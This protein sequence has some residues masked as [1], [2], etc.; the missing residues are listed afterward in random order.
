MKDFEQKEYKVFEMFSH[1]M[2]LV[3]ARKPGAFQRLHDW[4][5]QPGE[6]LVKGWQ[7]LPD[8]DRICLSFPIYL[9]VSKSK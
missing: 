7:C 4:L 3:T 6:Y 9:G 5:G 2:A 8:C 1:Q